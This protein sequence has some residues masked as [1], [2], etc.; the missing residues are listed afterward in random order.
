[1]RSNFYAITEQN[2]TNLDKPTDTNTVFYS[3]IHECFTNNAFRSFSLKYVIDNCIHYETNNQLFVVDQGNFMIAS[4]QPDVN[5]YFPS[6][7]HV[8]SIC[9]DIVPSMISE[10]FTILSAKG[11]YNL[12]N[13]MCGYF[14]HPNFYES[15]NPLKSAPALTSKIYR[16]LGSITRGTTGTLLNREWFLDL[17]EKLILHQHGDYLSLSGIYSVKIQTK[18]QIL[19]RLSIGK[20]YMDECFLTIEQIAEVANK[21]CLSEFLFFRT[22]KQAYGITPYKYLLRKR[23]GYAMSLFRLEEYT[24]EKVALSCNFADS[25]TFSK[26][27]KREFGTTPSRWRELNKDGL[28]QPVFH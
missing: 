11:D 21:C 24:F 23:L 9:I 16:L 6:N 8:R 4:K 17:A 15:V 18:K 12:D 7:K 1:M 19:R 3:D 20:Q 5:A 14:E 27:F 26:A 13:Y 2:K 25:C 22:F 28:L 10:A